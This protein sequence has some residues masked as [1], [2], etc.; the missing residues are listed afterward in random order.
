ML[1]AAAT[2]GGYS[3]AGDAALLGRRRADDR[4]LREWLARYR[5]MSVSPVTWLA[6]DRLIVETDVRGALAAIRVPTLVLHRR[7]N[8]W[9]RVGHGRY[10]LSTSRARLVEWKAM[11][12]FRISATSTR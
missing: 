12:T 8:A 11:S 10:W 4:E 5:R 9:M 7:D 3:H 2:G 1:S 6:T